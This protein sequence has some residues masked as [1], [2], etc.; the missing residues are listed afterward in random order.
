M[1]PRDFVRRFGDLP[2]AAKVVYNGNLSR[3]FIEDVR[4]GLY[5]VDEGVV[6]KGDGFMVKIKT[7]AYLKRLNEAYGAAYRNYWE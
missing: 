2:C 3:Q 4:T 5:P 7:Y 6:A 1:R